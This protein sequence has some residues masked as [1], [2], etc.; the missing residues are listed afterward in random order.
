MIPLWITIL[1]MF[2]GGIIG[3]LGA[4]FCAV[5]GKSDKMIEEIMDKEE[6]CGIIE[7]AVSE[8]GDCEHDVIQPT[9]DGP[10]EHFVSYSVDKRGKEKIMEAL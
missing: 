2:L 1:L 8:H 9:S 3:V 6:R 5:S 7:E 10:G 4:A